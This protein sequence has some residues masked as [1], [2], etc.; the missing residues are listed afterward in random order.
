[1]A[2]PVGG[3]GG[4]IVPLETTAPFQIR[5]RGTKMKLIPYLVLIATIPLAACTPMLTAKSRDTGDV[6]RANAITA[7]FNPDGSTPL[8]FD[9]ETYDG[10]WISVQAPTTLIALDADPEIEYGAATLASDKGNALRCEF[11]YSFENF[12]AK[13]ICLN[14][15]T[16]EI[17][18]LN[19]K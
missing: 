7:V 13:G 10:D 5:P 9:D 1:M 6:G 16:G 17:F 4:H 11:K 15:E 3:V 14:D 19:A 18:D 2:A 8:V 12:K